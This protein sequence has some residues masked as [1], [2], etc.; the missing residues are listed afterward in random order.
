MT[1]RPAKDVLLPSVGEELSPSQIRD[2]RRDG[3]F[4]LACD[5]MKSGKHEE[6]IEAFDQL[7]LPYAS[8]YQAKVRDSLSA[9]MGEDSL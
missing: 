4:F 8:Y 7:V 6:A 9:R 3:A 5:L 2:Y 1:A